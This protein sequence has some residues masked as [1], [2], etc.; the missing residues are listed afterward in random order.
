MRHSSPAVRREIILVTKVWDSYTAAH[1][2]EA[3]QGILDRLRTD[4]SWKSAA[5][6]GLEPFHTI[7]NNY[8]LAAPDLAREILPT[9][10]R[11]KIGLLTTAPWGRDF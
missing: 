9:T 8:D 6:N 3:I 2:I 4:F 11:E 10:R 1:F 7:E 5:A